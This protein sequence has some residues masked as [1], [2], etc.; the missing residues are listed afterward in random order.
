MV[1]AVVLAQE[2]IRALGITQTE[3]S[4]R[5]GIPQPKISRI[6]S[7]KWNNLTLETL[8]KLFAALDSDIDLR[9]WN[10]GCSIH[11][12]NENLLPPDSPACFWD[13][14]VKALRLPEHTL[15]VC[16]GL[17]GLGFINALRWL[18]S[19]MDRED[20]RKTLL[21]SR[22]LSPKSRNFWALFFHVSLRGRRA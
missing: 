5:A 22:R 4:K 16:E 15:L 21:E 7:G 11:R 9:L 8:E 19:H 2:R 1:S 17:I 6:L 3:L 12:K 10:S 13:I 14:D 20:I 18:L